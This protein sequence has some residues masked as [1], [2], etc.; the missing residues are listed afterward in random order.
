M[1]SSEVPEVAFKL[2]VRVKAGGANAGEAALANES[3]N[4]VLR[5]VQSLCYRVPMKRMA[6][7]L[8][9]ASAVISCNVAR[10]ESPQMLRPVGGDADN[11]LVAQIRSRNPGTL[12]AI[13]SGGYARLMSYGNEAVVDVDGVPTLLTYHPD[14]RGGA[15][16]AGEGIEISGKLARQRVTDPVA[17]LSNDVTVRVRARGRTVRFTASWTCQATLMTVRIRR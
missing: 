4:L 3:F 2:A 11:A 9:A 8:C 5:R 17:T 15:E 7:L 6:L 10:A 16:F 1:R 12:C 14:N 13:V